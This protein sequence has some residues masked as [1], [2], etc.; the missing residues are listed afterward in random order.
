MGAGTT[1]GFSGFEPLS[2][3]ALAQTAHGKG[4]NPGYAKMMREGWGFR[5][6][7]WVLGLAPVVL[8]AIL[9]FKL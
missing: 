6:F 7:I 9:L 8:V 2:Q 3:R 1:C 5:F 4:K